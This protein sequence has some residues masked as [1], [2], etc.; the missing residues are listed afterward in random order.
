MRR[1]RRLVLNIAAAVLP[2]TAVAAFASS[3]STSATPP[4]AGGMVWA[5][6]G[7]G[8]VDSDGGYAID[9]GVALLPND[10]A[11]IALN[12]GRTDASTDISDYES[13]SASLLA[14]YSWGP[15]G[16]SASTSWTADED[17][18]DRFRYG[19][20]I[21]AKA[22]QLR[23]EF[24]LEAGNND[25]ETFRFTI[26]PISIDCEVDNTAA[27][28][29]I[30][31]RGERLGAYASIK[32][33]NYSTPDCDVTGLPGTAGIDDLRR[34]VDV[35][36]DIVRRLTIGATAAARLAIRNAETSLLDRSVSAGVS[37]RHDDIQYGL[38]YYLSEEVLQG[39]EATTFSARMLFP[40]SPTVDVEVRLGVANG[41]QVDSVGFGGVSV[42]WY[43][44]TGT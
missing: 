25:F 38:D 13:T 14:D 2:L 20:S 4:P 35:A 17:F 16:I 33:Y 44:P 5:L 10:Q 41:D 30:S 15:I 31:L 26:L 18:V 39:L 29:R 32:S 34:F 40:A 24:G 7:G 1:S 42:Y 23:V 12:V 37:L 9:G 8:D 19:G 43:L 21:Y 22:K 3:G 28:A 11:L 6:S 36:P 27:S